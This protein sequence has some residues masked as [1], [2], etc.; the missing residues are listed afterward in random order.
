MVVIMI[1]VV[2]MMLVI[3]GPGDA[4]NRPYRQ[5]S[6]KRGKGLAIYRNEECLGMC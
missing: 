2:V 6:T 1:V 3:G 4:T 5:I